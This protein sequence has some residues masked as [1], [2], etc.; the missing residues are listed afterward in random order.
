MDTVDSLNP[1][2]SMG[3]L[4]TMDTMDSVDPVDSMGSMDTMHATDA[5]NPV[6]PLG[7]W[8]TG[9]LDPWAM[10]RTYVRCFSVFLGLLMPACLCYAGAYPMDSIDFTDSLGSVNAAGSFDY[11]VGSMDSLHR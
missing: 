2:D 10:P 6:E 3:S 5:V 8:A 1:L 7:H 11:A 9:P 4:Y